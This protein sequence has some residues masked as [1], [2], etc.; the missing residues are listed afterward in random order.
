[1]MTSV[2]NPSWNEVRFFHVTPPSVDLYTPASANEPPVQADTYRML[3]FVGCTAMEPSVAPSNVLLASNV[4][5]R[6][7]LVDFRMPAPGPETAPRISF[8]FAGCT[9]SG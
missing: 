9:T 8:L 5:P 4:H 6:P 7:A 2:T 3:V 1:M